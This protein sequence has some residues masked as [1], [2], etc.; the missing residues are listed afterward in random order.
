[1][2]DVIKVSGYR[3]GTAEI[4][5]ALVAHPTVAESAAIGVPDE[6]KGNVIY[7]FCILNSGVEGSDALERE[8]K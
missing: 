4:E 5:S 6:L 7:A 3:P 2:D 1:M 8:L